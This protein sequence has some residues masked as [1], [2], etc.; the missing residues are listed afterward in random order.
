VFT[1]KNKSQHAELYAP[2]HQFKQR[3]GLR[4]VSHVSLLCLYFLWNIC[5]RN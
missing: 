4:I 1:C 5:R 2:T 3:E